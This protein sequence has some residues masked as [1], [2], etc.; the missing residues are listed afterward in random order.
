MKSWLVFIGSVEK[1]NTKPLIFKHE[2]HTL[3][4]EILTPTYERH[5]GSEQT[6]EAADSS[7]SVQVHSETETH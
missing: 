6:E 3:C 1:K 7:L 4:G 2:D 5:R